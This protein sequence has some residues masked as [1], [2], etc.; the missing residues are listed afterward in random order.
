MNRRQLFTIPALVFCALLFGSVLSHVCAIE[1]MYLPVGTPHVF[2]A[3]FDCVGDDG[4]GNLCHYVWETAGGG[5]DPG[6]VNQVELQWGESGDNKHVYVVCI[7]A[8]GQVLN[9]CDQ[10]YVTVCAVD[11]LSVQN[12]TEEN[13]N[14][15][16]F[17]TP[18]AAA[19]D[20][21]ITATLTP[22]V[23][24]GVL[25][26]GF[27]TW[28]NGDAGA[29]Q[30]ERKVTK[31]VSCA[32]QVTVT[33]GASSKDV[34]IKVC[35]VDSLAVTGATEEPGNAGS[36]VAPIAA[37]GDVVITATL[38]PDVPAANLPADF[39]TWTNGN[40]GATQLQRKVT[41][42]V[43]GSTQVTA[44][45]G[46]SSKNATIVVCS[47]DSLTVAGADEETGNP[48]NYVT[49][50]AAAGDV[51]I[52]ATL[53]PNVPAANLPADFVTWT[54][55]DAG[56]SQLE[57]KVT[58]TVSCVTQVTATCGTSS[59][60]VTIKV[61]KVDSI[62][63]LNGATQTHVVG[64]KNWAAVKGGG[65]VLVQVT[66]TPV[67]SDAMA[68]Q[69][70]LTWTGGDAVAGSPRQRKVSKAVSAKTTVTA[71][72][73]T[74]SDHVDIWVLWSTVQVMVSGPRPTNAVPFNGLYDGTE[75]LGAK[76]FSNGDEAVGKVVPVATITPA[77]ANAVV[78]SGW[79]FEREKFRHDFLD[80]APWAARWDTAWQPDTSWGNKQVL[81]PDAGDKIYDRDAPNIVCAGCT[82]I[83]R[84]DNFREW[85]TWNG[86]I[87]SNKGVDGLWYWSAGAIN[88]DTPNVDWK[89]VNTGQLALPGPGDGHY[90]PP[91]TVTAVAPNNGKLA[92]GT[93]IT[94]SGTN[95]CDNKFI[96]VEIGGNAATA[97][98]RV[99][100]TTITCDTPAGT[101]GAK[102]VK[103]TVQDGGAD[104]KMN[105]F[106]Y[107]PAPTIATITP[108]TGPAAGGTPITISGTGFLDN[109]NVTIGGAAA[110][111]VTKVNDTTI[112]CTTPAGTAGTAK[113]VVVTNTD[114]QAATKT[115]GF[116]HQ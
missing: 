105:G 80:G 3:D 114:T 16:K 4:N 39:V 99:N 90:N 52:T 26:A 7:L 42:T 101:A 106:T 49:P 33:C 51:V 20:V 96:I 115:G 17:V 110:T 111:G 112:N 69:L 94:I 58:K 116:T 104:T 46:T 97:V 82:S 19:G 98:T 86:T 12:A 15:G 11:S 60:D 45:C 64:D 88:I 6:N 95:F 56:A 41:K 14:P 75:E 100:D 34:T 113:D 84:Q 13:G 2:A 102:N 36:F 87:C 54:N 37:A 9:K 22:D 107:N 67:D 57:R 10:W 31:T 47:V 44:T 74:S 40:A 43:S 35:K 23:Q 30:L 8:G 78:T 68:T 71:T 29:N 108:N 48:G 93:S 83:E 18:I 79:T 27:V 63:V 109:P 1:Y 21:V 76:S 70:G 5:D 77:G 53:S 85:T 61:C 28:T 92:G 81:T 24:A 72:V 62:T 50:I 55:G 38:S 65:D 73:G 89:D 25:P 103:V 91:P 66:L 32:T 59:K